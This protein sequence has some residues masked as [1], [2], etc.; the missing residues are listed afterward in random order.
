M[1][2][3]VGKRESGK[4]ARAIRWA[5]DFDQIMV[6]SN[7]QT[8]IKLWSN[9]A[10]VQIVSPCMESITKMFHDLNNTT[11]IVFESDVACTKMYKMPEVLELLAQ[12]AKKENILFLAQCDKQLPSF[13]YAT[14]NPT[15]AETSFQVVG[16]I[17]AQ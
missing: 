6:V 3:I 9:I 14:Q 16:E 10:K 11:C 7:N 15:L 13:L 8:H 2:Y 4:T 5:L 1:Q 17:K 12:Y